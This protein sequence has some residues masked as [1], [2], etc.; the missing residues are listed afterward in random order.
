[1]AE[2]NPP[3][4][5]AD[6]LDHR[7]RVARAPRTAPGSPSPR[8]PE[9]AQGVETLIA[10]LRER[11]VEEGRREAARLVAEAEAEGAR[12]LGAARA[13]A[14]R[15][16]AQ[17]RAAAQA[18][19]EAGR[20]AL[21]A[22]ARDAILALRADL[23][24]RF[25][26]NLQRMVAEAMDRRDLLGPVILALVGQAGA[27]AG[28]GPGTAIEITLPD[29]PQTLEELR[30]DLEAAR[31]SPLTRLVLEGVAASLGEGVV[32]KAGPAD[33]RGL[34]VRLVDDAVEIDLSDAAIASALMA[35]LRPRFR[36]LFEGIIA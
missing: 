1:M 2:D 31:Q 27:A 29:R 32:L 12:L 28:I 21:E 15:L 19:E 34:M 25:S 18:E 14:A 35:H 24:E 3:L 22:A 30:A 33:L 36:A 16:V 9:I 11:G 5:E 23:L 7:A 10:E 4:P 6:P 17:A 20:R 26:D 8:V 13:E